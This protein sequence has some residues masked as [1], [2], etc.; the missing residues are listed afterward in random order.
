MQNRDSGT[1]LTK[2]AFQNT[3][4]SKKVSAVLADNEDCQIFT[5]S[6]AQTCLEKLKGFVARTNISK[7]RDFG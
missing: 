3:C 5:R 7:N 1:N 4:E 2:I 6:V